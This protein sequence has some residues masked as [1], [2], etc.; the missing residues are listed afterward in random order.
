MSFKEKILYHQ[1]HPV[2]LT[3][4]WLAGLTALYF[5][6]EHDLITALLVAV[7]PPLLI[8]LFLILCCSTNFETLKE[9]QFGWYVQRYMGSG[10]Q[11]L[12]LVGYIVM[13]LGAW[14]NL[15]WLSFLGLLIVLSA[16]IRGLFLYDINE[17]FPSTGPA[18]NA[19]EAK[20]KFKKYEERLMTAS[21]EG[22][23]SLSD[24]SV[25][26]AALLIVA[27]FNPQQ[28]IEANQFIK[29]FI[30]LLLL[31]IPINFWCGFFE[32]RQEMEQNFNSIINLVSDPI[33]RSDME[34]LKKSLLPSPG[35]VIQLILTVFFTAAIVAIVVAVWAK[36]PL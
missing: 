9:S 33:A 2:K 35:R 5:F 34:R 22:F 20:E 32:L 12:R 18:L 7:V 14:Y 21:R 1:I 23:R 31:I 36:W 19:A 3:I 24:V 26:A 15:I 6:W 30:S 25:L 13:A 28:L 10:M 17:F 27:T 4:D 8:S 16:W 29:F 11:L